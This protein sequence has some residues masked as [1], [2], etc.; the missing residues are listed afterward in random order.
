MATQK[1]AKEES[2]RKKIAEFNKLLDDELQAKRAE[3]SRLEAEL[4]DKELLVKRER[5][6]KLEQERVE[7]EKKIAEERKG[8]DSDAVSTLTPLPV[9]TDTLDSAEEVMATGVVRYLIHC[10]TLMHIMLHQNC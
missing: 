7:R 10:L 6:D 3:L 1:Q 8:S 5:L 4:L 9:P 2:E